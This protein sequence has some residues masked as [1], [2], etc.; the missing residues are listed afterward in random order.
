MELCNIMQLFTTGGPR[1]GTGPRRT[2]HRSA[3][4]FQ[5]SKRKLWN[6]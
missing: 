6:Y 5:K 2:G 1:T 3:E 4:E